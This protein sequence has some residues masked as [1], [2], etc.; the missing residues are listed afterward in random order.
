MRKR[1]ALGAVLLA[2]LAAALLWPV[3]SDSAF[4]GKKGGGGSTAQ[5]DL[6]VLAPPNVTVT[7]SSAAGVND[8]GNVVG[9]YEDDAGGYFAYYYDRGQNSFQTLPGGTAALGVNNR[10]EIVGN[11]R[12][13]GFALYWKT[14][15]ATPDILDSL[16]IAGAAAATGIN[17]AGIAVGHSLDDSISSAVLWTVDALGVSGPIEL[18][19][20]AGDL[21]A[22]ARQVSE[23]DQTGVARVIGYSGDDIHGYDSGRAVLWIL[24]I[25]DAGSLQSSGAIDLGALAGGNS[26]GDGVNLSADTCGTSEYHFPFLKRYGQPMQALAMPRKAISGGAYD[27]ND[28][29]TVVGRVMFQAKSGSSDERAYL[30]SSGNAIDLNAKVSLGT[31]QVLETATGISNQGCIVG[32]GFFPTASEGMIAFLLIPK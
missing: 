12:D 23:F 24:W 21:H 9:H 2:P 1:F 16:T 26:T 29:A 11:N 4:A 25:D 6:I 8:A 19:P 27:L 15:Q 7:W 13:F 5:Y 31:S 28:G 18:P 22:I 30:W 10:G 3:S 17:D 32:M 20:I 14:S